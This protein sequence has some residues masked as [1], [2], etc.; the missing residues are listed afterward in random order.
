MPAK[1]KGAKTILVVDDEKDIRNA[2][3]RILTKEG[4]TILEAASG[5]ECLQVLKK[6]KPDLV[7]LDV[8]MPG[9]PVREVLKKVGNVKVALITVVRLSEAEREN[10]LVTKNVVGFIQKPFDIDGLLSKVKEI[11]K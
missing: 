9:T 7:L 11:L 3:V 10:L 1:K 6:A 8:M 4:Y 5:D 2:V